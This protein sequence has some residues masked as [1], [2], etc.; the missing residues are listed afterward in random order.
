MCL[1]KLCKFAKSYKAIHFV[2]K[3]MLISKLFVSIRYK[4]S[5]SMIIK[6]RLHRKM[7]SARN[8][9]G[10]SVGI[11]LFEVS[12][13]IMYSSVHDYFIFALFPSLQ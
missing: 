2:H 1:Y 4:T 6:K 7:K 5:I 9:I 3:E 10:Y 13:R 8:S 12:G 11:S